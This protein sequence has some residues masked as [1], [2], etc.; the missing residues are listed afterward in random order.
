MEIK[1]TKNASLISGIIYKEYKETGNI[2][3]D[4][5][6]FDNKKIENMNADEIYRA[7]SEL[8]RYNLIRL[9]TS[10]GFY[11]NDSFISLM[12]SLPKETLEKIKNGT[13]QIVPIIISFVEKLF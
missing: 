12:E 7:L 11:I 3:F 2:N 13:F 9:W 8:N 10:R 1:L 6:F 4:K 5:Y